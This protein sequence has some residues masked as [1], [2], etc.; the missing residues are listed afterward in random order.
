MS[1][2]PGTDLPEAGELPQAPAGYD[3]A[4][5]EEAFAAFADR[6][7]ELED[8]ASE[9]RAELQSLRAERSA[10]RP[11]PP[12]A[13]PEPRPIEHW[14]VEPGE[15]SPD[16]VAAVPAPLVRANPIPRLVLEG[17][18]LLLVALFAGLADLSVAWIV[19][20]MALAWA[21]VVAGEWAAAARRAH[22][23]LDEVAPPLGEPAAETTGPWGMPIVEATVVAAGPD[24]ESQTIV[25]KLPSEP[26]EPDEPAADE[27]VES[28]PPKRRLRLRRRQRQ[29]AE[30]GASD[31]WEA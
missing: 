20:V 11:R 19:L 26:E 25:T 28:A 2:L 4:R 24:A 7:R 23:R 22:W 5:V 3:P 8:V 9:L 15:A 14:P 17:A 10:P 6:V 13:D 12:R 21:L 27:A 29:P 1:N 16:W 31:P 30:A 18:F